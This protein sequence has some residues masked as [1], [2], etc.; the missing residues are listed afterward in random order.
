MGKSR[1]RTS[2]GECEYPIK[3]IE[4][5]EI[6]PIDGILIC[7]RRAGSPFEKIV[8]PSQIDGLCP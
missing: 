6:T 8:R 2:S 7:G 3:P 1:A 5:V 4:P